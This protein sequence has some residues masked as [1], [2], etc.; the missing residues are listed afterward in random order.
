MWVVLGK[1]QVQFIWYLQSIGSCQFREFLSLR[2]SYYKWSS[3]CPQ[4]LLSRYGTDIPRTNKIPETVLMGHNSFR[5]LILKIKVKPCTCSNTDQC[6]F[7]EVIMHEKLI[8]TSIHEKPFSW[9]QNSCLC[10]L[11]TIHLVNYLFANWFWM[12]ISLN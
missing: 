2:S 1:L 11:T 12:V 8:F 3:Q 4:L 7:L 10:L 6:I 5:Y 9:N